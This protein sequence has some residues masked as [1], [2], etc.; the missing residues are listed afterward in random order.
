MVLKYNKYKKFIPKFNAQKPAITSIS[1][2][3]LL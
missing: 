1:V 3:D 2:S